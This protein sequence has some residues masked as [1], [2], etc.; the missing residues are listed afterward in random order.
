[1]VWHCPFLQLHIRWHHVHS[2]T[3]ARME[4]F[5]RQKPAYATNQD[6]ISCKS[7][8]SLTNKWD[9]NTYFL[10]HLYKQTKISTNISGDASTHQWCDGFASKLG[11]IW[12]KIGLLLII[13]VYL[14]NFLSYKLRGIK[15]I[16][17]FKEGVL[18]S[19]TKAE[20][21]VCWEARR[22]HLPYHKQVAT[23]TQTSGKGNTV[24]G[25]LFSHSFG[26]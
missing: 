18:S 25:K 24:P 19:T 10:I 12:N 11:S 1:M 3:W 5:I 22:G 23:S 17:L 26:E 16:R 21:P 20:F 8:T 2:L 4:V 7:L 15:R 6:L 9:S 13:L 14:K